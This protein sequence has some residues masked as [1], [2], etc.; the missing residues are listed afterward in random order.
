VLR[1]EV[2]HGRPWME[3]P[4]TVVHDG[5]GCLAVLLEPG[6]PFRFFD[7]PFGPHPWRAHPAWT[8]SA[9]LQVQRDGEAHAAWR[10]LGPPGAARWYVN[11]QQPVVR[12]V[13]PGGDGAFET[14]DLGIDIVCAPD[15]RSWE[16]KDVDDPDRMVA[17]GRI[18]ASER[19]HVRAE[20]AAV[21]AR[22][23]AGARWWAPWDGW[24]P[25]HPA[26]LQR[27]GGV[28]RA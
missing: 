3:Q 5:D 25:G 20:A 14:A 10:F 19:D 11:F 23:D 13:G 15:G 8:G 6:S 18:S 28:R 7:H 22:L 26:P 9:V 17:S 21:A 12:H 27:A 24:L 2:L 4:V 1:R 16:W